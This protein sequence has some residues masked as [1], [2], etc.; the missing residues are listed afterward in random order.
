MC[1]RRAVSG[2][3]MTDTNIITAAEVVLGGP[4]E[5]MRLLSE[6]LGKKI[7]SNYWYR[8]RAGGQRIPSDVLLLLQEAVLH[9]KFRG[10]ADDILKCIREP[11][12]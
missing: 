8:W 12:K 3:R 11:D 6:R 4:A 9:A 7:P 10:Q 1:W 2:L 5:A